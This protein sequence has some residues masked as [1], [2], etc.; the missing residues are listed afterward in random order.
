M[1]KMMKKFVLK[2]VCFD[3]L[4]R[5][6][7]LKVKLSFI[8]TPAVTTVDGLPLGVSEANVGKRAVAW[9]PGWLFIFCFLGLEMIVFMKE[10]DSARVDCI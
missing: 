1:K 5:R 4:G 8:R 3:V 10:N 2:F 7:A 6:N 9:S